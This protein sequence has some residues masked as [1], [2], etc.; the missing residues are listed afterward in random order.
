MEGSHEPTMHPM[1]VGADHLAM[2]APIAAE[3]SH[4][5][6]GYTGF[7]SFELRCARGASFLRA[8]LL[9]NC[10]D[11]V[12]LEFFGPPSHKRVVFPKRGPVISKCTP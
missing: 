4:R 11:S 1:Q 8:A 10:M 2:A 6:I 3:P 7:P 12:R 9:Y 5:H